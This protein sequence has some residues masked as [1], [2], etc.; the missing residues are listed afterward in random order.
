MGPVVATDGIFSGDVVLG[1]AMAKVLE[2]G[3][4]LLSVSPSVRECSVAAWKSSLMASLPLET[5]V[6]ITESVRSPPP[7]TGTLRVCVGPGNEGS[8]PVLCSTD[9]HWASYWGGRLKPSLS[10]RT[11][12]CSWTGVLEWRGSRGGDDV[13]LIELQSWMYQH[14]LPSRRVPTTDTSTY[15]RHETTGQRVG[16]QCCVFDATSQG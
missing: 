13:V 7:P 10:W 2:A 12:S 8:G 5:R 11:G 1:A 16:R 6:L 9:S 15:L 3:C 4:P 14:M